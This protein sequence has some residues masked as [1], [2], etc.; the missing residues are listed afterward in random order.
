VKK[1]V[2]IGI[3]GASGSIYAK[4]LIDKLKLLENQIKE[5]GIVFSKNAKD[6]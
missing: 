6:V 2:A 1:K 3:T 5:V 4:V